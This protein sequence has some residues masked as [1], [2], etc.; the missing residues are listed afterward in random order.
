MINMCC[1][2]KILYFLRNYEMALQLRI[3]FYE[4]ILRKFG[5]IRYLGKWATTPS[6][7][8]MVTA[9]QSLVSQARTF[10]LQIIITSSI[11]VR[12]ILRPVL[13]QK[14]SGRKTNRSLGFV[15]ADSFLRSRY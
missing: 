8:Q 13:F 7:L 5:A 3:Y 15:L 12:T 4:I 6:L 1:H 11:S 14:T 2:H 9:Y 10:L